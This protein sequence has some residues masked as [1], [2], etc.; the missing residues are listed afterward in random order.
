[1][2]LCAAW[3]RTGQGDEGQEL[4]FATDS[5]LRMGEE[6]DSGIKLFTLG[7]PDCLICFAGDTQRAYTMILQGSNT[8]QFN[9]DW[10]DPRLDLHDVRDLLCDLFTKLGR[11]IRNPAGGQKIA[12][13]VGSA[14]FLFGGWSWRKERLCVWKIAYSNE[15]E[16]F[17]P[18]AMHGGDGDRVQLPVFIG[19]HVETARRLLVEDIGLDVIYGDYDMQPLR[20]LARM[21]RS[22]E[23]HEI[24]GAIQIAKVYR[25]GHNEFFGMMWPPN[26]GEPWFLGRKISPYDAPPI[27]FI[28]PEST[29]FVEGLPQDF[30]DLDSY[31]FLEETLFVQKC[32]PQKKLD[33]ALPEASRNRLKRIFRDI[34]YR[35]FVAR[36]EA[37]A[38]V[39]ASSDAAE[40]EADTS[41]QATPTGQEAHHE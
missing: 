32:Y 29:R 13:V 18:Q 24:G 2:T 31:D 39:T 8:H 37:A 7:R 5:R 25:S 4:V 27:R 19:D 38:L 35:E 9:V 22:A 26:S 33:P 3:I 10:S 20:V 30:D 34:A 17:V 41:E 11:A 21:S 1:M 15:L 36:C 12:D 6:W 40:T 14:T 28:D 23:Y 16:S